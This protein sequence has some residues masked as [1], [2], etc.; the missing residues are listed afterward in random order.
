[1]YTRHEAHDVSNGDRLI[2][3][4]QLC[5]SAKRQPAHS[6][7][8]FDGRRYR[9]KQYSYDLLS[10][11]VSYAQLDASSPTFQM[12]PYVC[13]QWVDVDRPAEAD[14]RSM[15]DLN[16]TF[17]GKYYRYGDDRYEHFA[18]A[19]NYAKLVGQVRS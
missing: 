2:E 7:V 5:Q 16:I 12:E 11:A 4:E 13:P 1:M 17:D 15:V 3:S 18:D 6:K 14:Q 10:D 9:Y 19:I 8:V